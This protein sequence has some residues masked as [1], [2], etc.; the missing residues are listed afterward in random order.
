MGTLSS[1]VLSEEII[2]IS[3]DYCVNLTKIAVISLSLSMWITV[4][5]GLNQDMTKLTPPSVL[6]RNVDG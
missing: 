3:G 4:P 5:E 1:L 6:L 2:L